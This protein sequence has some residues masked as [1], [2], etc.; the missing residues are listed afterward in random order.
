MVY[1]RYYGISYRYGTIEKSIGNDITIRKDTKL[2]YLDNLL[3]RLNDLFDSA[4]QAIR[5]YNNAQSIVKAID[6]YSYE[7]WERTTN[8]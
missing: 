8:F 7:N 4:D 1:A 3:D 2:P 6:L 5:G